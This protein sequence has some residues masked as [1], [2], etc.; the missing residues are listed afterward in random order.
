[1]I[2]VIV[3]RKLLILWAPY[4]FLRAQPVVHIPVCTYDTVKLQFCSLIRF[5]KNNLVLRKIGTST[6]VI[7]SH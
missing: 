7:D 5:S 4:N 1:M 2:V 6:V 3:D